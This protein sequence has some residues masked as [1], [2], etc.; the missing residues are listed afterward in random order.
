MKKFK[1]ID[2]KVL[3]Y[4]DKFLLL[5]TTALFI[6]GLV[7]IFSSSNVAAFMRYEASPYRF[8]EKQALFLVVG[9]FLSLIIVSRSTKTYSVISWLLMVI[10]IGLLIA[11]L[12]YGKIAGKARSWLPLGPFSF[13]PSEFIKIITIVWLASWFEIRRKA[14]NSKL[15][16]IVPIVA[17]VFVVFLILQQPDLGTAILY[18][19]IVFFTCLMTRINWKVKLKTICLLVFCGVAGLLILNSYGKQIITETQMTKLDYKNPCSEEKFYSSG[20]QVCN[21]YIAFHNGG[22]TG[23]GLGNSTQKYLYLPEAHTDFIF[24]IV[25]EELG[26][27][28]GC[29]VLFFMFL[30]ILDVLVIGRCSNSSRGSI[31][32]YGI[33]GYIFVHI[34]VNLL[35][36]MGAMPITG[37]PLPF[38]SYGGS[39]TWCL[40]GSLA[41][42]QRVAIETKAQKLGVVLEDEFDF[43]NEKKE[44][45]SNIKKDT[46]VKTKSKAKN[47]NTVRKTKKKK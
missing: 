29:V 7:M 11:V 27:I 31:I 43:G 14:L 44:K 42:V 41:I 32:C 37:V 24:A 46:K 1:L 16:I 17:F 18:A 40:M 4:T 19:F 36:I 34:V 25:V 39:F 2:T 12:L 23:M 33:S 26:I 30:V 5:V 20:N 45:V 10:F 8:F 47:T 9:L 38:L 15:T 13:Q 6:F 3:R 21:S 35:G 28:G 22:L